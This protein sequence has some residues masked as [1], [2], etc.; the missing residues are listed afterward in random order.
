MKHIA[1]AILLILIVVSAYIA[2]QPQY[3]MAH[4]T[5][6]RTMRSLGFSYQTIL[7]YELNLHWFLHVVVGLVG[8]VLLYLSQLYFTKSSNKRIIT[9]F[10]LVTAM[11]LIAEWLQSLIGRNVEIA[12]LA[13][14]FL[15]TSVATVILVIFARLKVDSG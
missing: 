1:R 4:W 14:G 13:F 9:G 10:L 2:F 6:N 12:D 7:A 15:G 11:S 8:T 3:N 5:P